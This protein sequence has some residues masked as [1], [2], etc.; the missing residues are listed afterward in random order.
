MFTACKL[1]FIARKHNFSSSKDTFP[2]I[3]RPLWRLDKSTNSLS[4]YLALALPPCSNST[5]YLPICQFASSSSVFTAI[6]AFSFASSH[7]FEISVTSL[8][9][10][11][12]VAC[13]WPDVCFIKLLFFI[14]ISF[15]LSSFVVIF[16][17]SPRSA[18]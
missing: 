8:T 16:Q 18:I 13:S 14:F 5:I 6:A 11:G 2:I 17:W 4:P 15:Y 7:T 9:Y 3:T 12:S 1:M 10:S